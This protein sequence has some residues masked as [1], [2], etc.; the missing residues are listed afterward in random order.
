[1]C[2]FYDILQNILGGV[3]E[4]DGALVISFPAI[5]S[6]Q[7]PRDSPGLQS[8]WT[9]GLQ[10]EAGETNWSHL[11]CLLFYNLCYFPKVPES[12][13]RSEWREKNE[14][15]IRATITCCL[16]AINYLFL[17]AFLLLLLIPSICL[18]PPWGFFC[19]E[20]RSVN[21]SCGSCT[22][23]CNEWHQSLQRAEQC[24]GNAFRELLGLRR[25]GV[26]SWRRNFILHLPLMSRW[27]FQR[28]VGLPAQIIPINCQLIPSWKLDLSTH[29]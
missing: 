17:V 21:Q 11:S 4:G 15:L 12:C 1:M 7:T 29:W 26:L 28:P 24:P 2:W 18:M 6:Q 16:L 14:Y 22:E 5:H 20:S 13:T 25:A 23:P 8:L 3:G 27:L 9:L 10:T 19:L